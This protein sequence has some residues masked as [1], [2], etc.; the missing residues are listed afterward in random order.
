MAPGVFA[1]FPRALAS[2]SVHQSAKSSKS[3]NRTGRTCHLF[4]LRW[5]MTMM[6]LSGYSVPEQIQTWWM[7]PGARL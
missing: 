7:H 1:P 2:F 4:P 5:R 6:N 3:S